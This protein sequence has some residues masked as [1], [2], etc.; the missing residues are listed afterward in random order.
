MSGLMELST[1]HMHG[2][3]S[4][5]FRDI[6]FSNFQQDSNWRF[7]YC[8][9]Y[10]SICHFFFKLVSQSHN[11]TCPPNFQSA[12]VTSASKTWCWPFHIW[13]LTAWPISEPHVSL[14]TTLLNCKEGTISQNTKCWKVTADSLLFANDF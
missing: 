1:W 7:F 13:Y 5:T 14:F 9:G 11:V 10:R 6:W 12:W 3:N 8:F 4:D 2:L